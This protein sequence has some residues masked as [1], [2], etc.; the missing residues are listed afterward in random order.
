MGTDEI[1][2][3]HHAGRSWE[4]ARLD[5]LHRLRALVGEAAAADGAPNPSP[6]LCVFAELRARV[7]PPGGAD[8]RVDG[9]A[10]RG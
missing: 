9:R 8:G 1:P 3:V 7:G 2:P 10:T 5:E 6:F 4:P